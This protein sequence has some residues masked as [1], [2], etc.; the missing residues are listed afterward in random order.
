MTTF[1][2]DAERRAAFANMSAGR[3]FSFPVRGK[4][5]ISRRNR[6]ILYG[7]GA[8]GLVGGA[9][10][11]KAYRKG[12]IAALLR[13]TGYVFG[14]PGMNP[15]HR[16]YG[17]SS[18]RP[19][20]N[21]TE[22]MLLKIPG[23]R[24]LFGKK[25]QIYGTPLM[26]RIRMG[27]TRGRVRKVEGGGKWKTPGLTGRAA[28]VVDRASI[29]NVAGRGN[30]HSMLNE[31]IRDLSKMKLS[32]AIADVRRRLVDAEWIPTPQTRKKLKQ[33][34]DLHSAYS[35]ED[36]SSEAIAKLSPGAQRWWKGVAY[37]FP[38]ETRLKHL[39]T[40][41]AKFMELNKQRLVYKPS[42]IE[43][44]INTRVTPAERKLQ[45]WDWKINRW[46]RRKAKKMGVK[47]V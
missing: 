41:R 1:A 24:K 19:P 37:K 44:L 29:W 13:P 14:N 18:M 21:A 7:L 35:L 40:I 15:A 9:V 4:G 38:R 32:R 23:I 26:S 10:A 8:A 36:F 2:S 45:Q 16:I 27:L 6:G 39:K 22:E 5:G 42:Y 34:Q 47:G 30:L 46:V 12:D 28:D 25:G 31:G 17:F 3:R 20:I 11:L 43:H 33:L